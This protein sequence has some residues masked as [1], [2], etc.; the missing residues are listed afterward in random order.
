MGDVTEVDAEGGCR[1]FRL[2]RAAAGFRRGD[3]L[4]VAPGVEPEGGELVVDLE[5]KLG[6]HGGGPVLG[7]V[8]GVVRRGRGAR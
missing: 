2:D 1:A 5:G 6:R 8:V 7:V 3:V 4:L